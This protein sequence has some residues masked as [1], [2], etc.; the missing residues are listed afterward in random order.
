M[1]YIVQTSDLHK[2]GE[3]KSEISVIIRT[4]MFQM[5][6]SYK[7]EIKGEIKGDDIGDVIKV[8]AFVHIR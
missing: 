2:L 7:G 4:K 5:G 1:M 8:R 3:K 6:V